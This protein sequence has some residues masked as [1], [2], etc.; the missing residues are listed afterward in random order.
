MIG[1]LVVGALG[2]LDGGMFGGVD[3]DAL[4]VDGLE[5]VVVIAG[6]EGGVVEGLAVA[7]AALQIYI[8]CLVD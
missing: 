8:D 4:A 7:G 3:L 1:P 6:A 2:E 5:G